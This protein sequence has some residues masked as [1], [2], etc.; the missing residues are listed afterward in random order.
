M[1]IQGVPEMV[2]KMREEVKPV[3]VI[4]QNGKDFTCKMKTPTCT[5]V[6]S[7][8]LGKES[9]MTA[10]DGRKFKVIQASKSSCMLWAQKWRYDTADDA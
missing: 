8:T 3:F 9:E 2:V 4:E 6:H 7:F 1:C 5:A 10:L